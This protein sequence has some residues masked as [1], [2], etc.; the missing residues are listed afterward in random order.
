MNVFVLSISMCECVCVCWCFSVTLDNGE[1]LV[2]MKFL[3]ATVAPCLNNS[4]ICVDFVQEEHTNSQDLA[5]PLTCHSSPTSSE[6][7]QRVYL[8]HSF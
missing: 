5:Q 4:F 2:S 7:F 8:L 1:R 3:K 6:H